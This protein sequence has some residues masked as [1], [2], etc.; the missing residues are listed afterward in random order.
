MS[1][2]NS[3]PIKSGFCAIAEGLAGRHFYAMRPSCIA[4]ILLPLAACQAPVMPAA[5]DAASQPL[6]DV[7]GS[8]HRAG[9]PSVLTVQGVLR[10]SFN[11]YQ[12]P[13]GPGRGVVEVP[14][15]SDPSGAPGPDS[16]A[17]ALAFSQ[18]LDGARLAAIAR[19]V[20]VNVRNA[21]TIRRDNETLL[22]CWTLET[23]DPGPP[24]IMAHCMGSVADRYVQIIVRTADTPAEWR[25][26]I[27]F[28]AGAVLALRASPPPD[29]PPVPAPEGYRPLPGRP[30]MQI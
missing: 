13:A 22:R 4:L 18:A 30:A 2:S 26:A 29:I 15:Q 5:R 7:I 20:R 1:L 8:Y 9:P 12:Q 24:S 11:P 19:Q 28:A 27:E 23:T 6:P 10:G 21:S 17:F 3:S 14:E 25:A 16:P